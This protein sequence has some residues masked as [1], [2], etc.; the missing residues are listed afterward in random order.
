[1]SAGAGAGDYGSSFREIYL[2]TRVSL[3]Q[4]L[5]DVRPFVWRAC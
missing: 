3:K 5:W 4:S 2:V 1:M